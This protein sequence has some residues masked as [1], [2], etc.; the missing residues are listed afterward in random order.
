MGK[1]LVKEIFLYSYKKDLKTSYIKLGLVYPNT[2]KVGMSNLGF[3][4]VFNAFNSYP[5]IVVERFFLDTRGKSFENNI[6]LSFMD[7]IAV[8]ISF[9]SDVINLLKILKEGGVEIFRGKRRSVLI[10]GGIGTPYVM[11]ILWNVVD[12]FLIGEGE[13]LIQRIYKALKELNFQ[14]NDKE[15]FLEKLKTYIPEAIIPLYQENDGYLFID[16]SNI[17]R[18]EELSVPPHT[19]IFSLEKVKEKGNEGDMEE[20]VLTNLAL[21]MALIEISRGCKY[22]CRFCALRSLQGRFREFPIDYIKDTLKKF[23]GITNKVG[24]ISASPL[25]YSKLHELVYYTNSLGLQVSFSSLR[26]EKIKEEFIEIFVANGNQEVTLAPE[27]ASEKIKK[28]L[29][30][31]MPNDIFIKVIKKFYEK[32]LRKFKLY[33][34]TNHPEE[35]E[36]DIKE[37]IKFLKEIAEVTKGSLIIVDVN[38]LVPKYYT[39]FENLSIAD[40]DTI[41]RTLE[42]FRK[43]VYKIEGAKFVFRNMDPMEAYMEWII[44]HSP[45]SAFPILQ[46]LLENKISKKKFLKETHKLILDTINNLS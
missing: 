23:L 42:L 32:G 15:K 19:V 2:Y 33:F 6:F 9:E 45:V 36:E 41:E 12:V 35:T 31:Y 14:V 30:K 16:S 7:I 37:N 11:N 1:G 40:I 28:M 10:V 13:A 17:A 27:S 22:L 24:F 4:Y 21:K 43:E 5:E 25:D 26:A 29:A 46:N 44:S 20:W 8:S 39:P 18:A 3:Q 34:I 38:P